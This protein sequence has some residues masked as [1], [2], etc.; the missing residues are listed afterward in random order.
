MFTA[1]TIDSSLCYSTEQWQISE[2]TL[3]SSYDYRNLATLLIQVHGLLIHTYIQF[4][5]VTK[6]SYTDL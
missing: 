1:V 6:I 4:I 5:C 2:S 3:C